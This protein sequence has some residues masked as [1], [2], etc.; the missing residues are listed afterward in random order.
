MQLAVARFELDLLRAA[1]ALF[2]RVLLGGG[3]RLRPRP[4]PVVERQR[5]VVRPRVAVRGRRRPRRRRLVDGRRGDFPGRLAVGR[6][7]REQR[8]RGRAR[9]G[10]GVARQVVDRRG[11]LVAFL[12]SALILREREV[13]LQRGRVLR[14]RVGRCVLRQCLGREAAGRQRRRASI[15][16]RPRACRRL[17]G[18][19]RRRGARR[20]TGERL[21]LRARA[22]REQKRGRRRAQHRDIHAAK[23]R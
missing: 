16:R 1:R 19:V 14:L 3:V 17:R 13:A 15:G 10:L 9:G 2:L 20:R 8:R 5:R 4:A 22:H 12:L 21:R 6:A 18:R 23:R 7:R 11:E